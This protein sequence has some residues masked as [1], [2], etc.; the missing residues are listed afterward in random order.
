[1]LHSAYDKKYLEDSDGTEDFDFIKQCFCGNNDP[2]E[3]QTVR[4]AY[5]AEPGDIHLITGHHDDWVCIM[6]GKV[7][8]KNQLESWVHIN[9]QKL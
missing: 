6:C 1:M 5:D 7:S 3:F 4:E 9:D 8:N 2:S